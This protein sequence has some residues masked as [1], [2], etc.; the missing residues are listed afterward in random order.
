MVWR[1]FGGIEA[2]ILFW[3]D[4]WKVPFDVI[5]CQRTLF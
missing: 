1:I 3:G 2:P 5:C 4:M